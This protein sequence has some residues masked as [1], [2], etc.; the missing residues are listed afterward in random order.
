MAKIT[1][2]ISLTSADLTSDALSINKTA[3]LVATAAATFDQTSG[4]TRLNNIDTGA[5][6]TISATADYSFDEAFLYIFNTDSTINNTITIKAG[7]TS[8][9]KLYGGHFALLPFDP[10]TNAVVLIATNA[11][12]T[13]EYQIFHRG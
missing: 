5:G 13:V 2:N 6:T 7:A 1:A 10:S 4:L 8:I 11:S 12:T 3:S 9:G